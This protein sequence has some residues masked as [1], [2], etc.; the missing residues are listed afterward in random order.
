MKK[1]VHIVQWQTPT[2]AKTRISM[3]R[4]QSGVR[5][6]QKKTPKNRDFSGKIRILIEGDCGAWHKNVDESFQIVEKLDREK[7]EI[8]Y[9]S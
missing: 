8:W 6:T 9:L 1:A 3:L 5:N 7:F 2:I 4:Y